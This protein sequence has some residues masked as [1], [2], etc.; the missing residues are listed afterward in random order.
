MSDLFKKTIITR[1]EPLVGGGE[2]DQFIPGE[3]NEELNQKTPGELLDEKLV[4]LAEQFDNIINQYDMLLEVLEKRANL[5]NIKITQKDL[6]NNKAL[7]DACLVVFGERP[8]TLNFNTY[9][10]VLKYQQVFAAEQVSKNADASTPDDVNLNQ[11]ISSAGP[12]IQ[13]MAVIQQAFVKKMQENDFPE[14][15]F[16]NAIVVNQQT[17]ASAKSATQSIAERNDNHSPFNGSYLSPREQK[18]FLKDWLKDCF[19]C[20]DRSLYSMRDD[21]GIRKLSLLGLDYL[22]SSWLNQLQ[23]LAKIKMAIADFNLIGNFCQFADFLKTKVNCVPDLLAL[24]YLYKSSKLNFDKLIWNLS[25]EITDF[26]SVLMN[27][28][29]KGVGDAILGVMTKIMA[30]VL[31]P[32]YCILTELEAHARKIDPLYFIPADQPVGA[33]PNLVQDVNTSLFSKE[34]YINIKTRELF[35][36]LQNKIITIS[37][38]LIN[39]SYGTN[40]QHTSLMELTSEIA[41]I[42]P[43]IGMVLSFVE[44]GKSMEFNNKDFNWDVFVKNVCVKSYTEN[45]SWLTAVEIPNTTI[46]EIL[47]KNRGLSEQEGGAS[48][49]AQN[50]TS[51]IIVDSSLPEDYFAEDDIETLLNNPIFQEAVQKEDEKASLEKGTS[52]FALDNDL[53]K[54][55]QIMKDSFQTFKSAAN[56]AVE[57]KESLYENLKAGGFYPSKVINTSSCIT[58]SGLSGYTEEQIQSWISKVTS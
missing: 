31:S 57:E 27:F 39:Q 18:D 33:L 21:L 48:Q 28:I 56:N 38:Q 2:V 7:A 46:N 3:Y 50:G 23:E 58:S 41:T 53:V 42:G 40:K 51:F 35:N 15:L 29:L 52:P 10:K 36:D 43:W 25:L 47:S 6:E 16:T 5:K 54:R 17:A 30:S 9:I 22:L 14:L 11:I 26:T 32:I 13:A 55:Y 12:E 20:L 24:Y 19:P 34:Q 49:V 8:S 37:N 1:S 4:F 44:L 45:K